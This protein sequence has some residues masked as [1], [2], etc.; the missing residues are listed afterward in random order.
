MLWS[1]TDYPTDMR[2]LRPEVRREAI[3]IANGVLMGGGTKQAAIAAGLEGAVG[4]LKRD[5]GLD[6]GESPRGEE[7]QQ[8]IS[9]PAPGAHA[10]SATAAVS[11]DPED[12]TLHIVGYG[13]LRRSQ[14]E[15]DVIN[16]LEDIVHR[17]QAGDWKNAIYLFKNGIPG[18]MMDTLDQHN[19]TGVWYDPDSSTYKKLSHPRTL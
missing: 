13:V 7:T 9:A 10:F 17:A 1:P 8:T 5:R 18:A 15:K 6:E 3:R 14:I 19:R 16:R 11:E 12:P 2:H 4:A